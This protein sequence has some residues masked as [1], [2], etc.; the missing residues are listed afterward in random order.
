MNELNLLETE[1]IANNN[2]VPNS[3]ERPNIIPGVVDEI[4]APLEGGKPVLQAILSGQ[5][6][7]GEVETVAKRIER[8]LPI[9][10]RIAAGAAAKPRQ[11]QKQY[12]QNAVIRHLSSEAHIKAE[13]HMASEKH[14]KAESEGKMRH[15]SSKAHVMAEKHV[16]QIGHKRARKYAKKYDDKLKAEKEKPK[17]SKL[18]RY[19]LA[20]E[21]RD[22]AA[23]KAL[24][25]LQA[26]EDK[27]KLKAEKAKLKADMI[28]Q[29][30][31]IEPVEQPVDA[32]IEVNKKILEDIAPEIPVVK[33]KRARNP[34][35]GKFVKA[36]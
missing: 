36:K 21:K 35:T 13:K 6:Q 19:E 4:E 14:M 22:A 33:P 12:L 2:P 10:H 30:Q 25:K 24:K 7:P 16:K 9:I 5:S 23:L 3:V 15:L 27:A 8:A 18:E 28:Q 1:S 29:S 20:K 31:P 11:R 26:K 32:S 17:L 34:K